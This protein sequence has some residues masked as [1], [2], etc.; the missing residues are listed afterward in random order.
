MSELVEVVVASGKGGVGK[1]LFTSELAL[2][3]AERGIEFVTAD[4]DAEAP[5]LHVVLGIDEWDE[6]RVYREGRVARILQEKC[7][8]CGL[9]MDACPLGAVEIRDGR[10]VINQWICE[11]CFT[12][13]FVCPVK[14]IRYSFNVPAGYIRIRHRTPY[15]FPLVSGEIR[16]GRPNSGKLVT[17]VKNTAH[18]L[19]GSRG[20]VVLVDA[21]AGIGCQVISSLAGAHIAILVTEPTPAGFH[22]L[23]RIHRLLLHFGIPAALVIN[24]YDLNPGYTEKMKSYAAQHN[25]DVIG[26]I[27]YDE[28]VP[29]AAVQRKPLTQV[30]PDTPAAKAIKRLVEK[31]LTGIIGNWREWRLK[32]LPPKTIPYIPK[33]IKPEQMRRQETKL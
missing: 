16:P 15:G 32:H 3:L 17:E 1:T 25:I 14:A 33:T 28:N 6:V 22:D 13:S 30:Y 20:G 19:L 4:A 2:G 23:R 10:Y 11:G 12:C 31:T 29:R 26:T 7:I 9:C 24:K 5:N 8:D 21:A 18:G 27:P